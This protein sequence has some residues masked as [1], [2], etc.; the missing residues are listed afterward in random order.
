[1]ELLPNYYSWTYGLFRPYITGSVLELGCGAGLGIP[2]YI[3]L[4]QHIYAVDFNEELLRRVTEKFPNERVQAIKSDLEGSWS[5]LEGI[6]ADTI[7][8]MDVLGH[9]ADDREVLAKARTFLKPG[10]RICLKVP[11]QSQLFSEMDRA[12]GLYRRHDRRQIESLA[13]EF[14]FRI[15]LI[16]HL[17]QIGALVYRM[18]RHN[19]TTFS[20]TFSATQLKLINAML[21]LIATLDRLQIIPG[22]SLIAVLEAPSAQESAL[23]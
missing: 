7:I 8:M 18:K 5:E 23:T 19:T 9:L 12:S 17:N 22:L 1:M 2:T 6:A 3:G 16:K 11:A 21:P 14:G 20:K 13:T 4:A 15:K 10:G